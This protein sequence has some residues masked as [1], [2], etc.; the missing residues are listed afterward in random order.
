MDKYL[1]GPEVLFFLGVLFIAPGSLAWLVTGGNL[2]QVVCAFLLWFVVLF[3]VL[4]GGSVSRDEALGWTM[5]I[6]MF[7]GWAGV[8][9]M[10]LI[11]RAVDVPYRFF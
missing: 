11:L 6:S 9:L 10:A 4:G 3:L 5:I 7:I 2:L 1:P 8:P